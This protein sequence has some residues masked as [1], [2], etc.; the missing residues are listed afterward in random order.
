MNKLIMDTLL[1]TNIPV[2]FLYTPDLL[3]QYIVFAIYYE[4][5]EQWA[6]NTETLT[7]YFVQVDVYS[8]SDYTDIVLNVMTLMKNAG[9]TRTSAMDLYESDTK[10]YHKAIRFSYQTG[11]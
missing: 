7:N 6:D 4:T 1:E 3:T 10:Y 8:K 5:G 2:Y 11:G 9:F